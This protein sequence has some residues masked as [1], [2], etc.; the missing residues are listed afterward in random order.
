MGSNS[1]EVV[2]VPRNFVLLEELEKAEKG[3]GDMSVSLGLSRSDDIFMSDWQ[4]TILGPL[5]SPID[6]RIISLEI[7][8]SERYPFEPPQVRMQNKVNYPFVDAKGMVDPTKLPI[9]KQWDRLH[10]DQRRLE[11]VLVD[12]KKEFAKPEYKKNVQPPD[13]TTYN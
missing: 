13:G 9:L 4:C 12:L 7:H 8:C 10:K 1:G 11:A 6:G 5:G 2:I 3:V